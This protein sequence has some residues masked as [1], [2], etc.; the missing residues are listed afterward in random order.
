VV[1]SVCIVRTDQKAM[2]PRNWLNY[3]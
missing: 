3:A 2:Y 1:Y